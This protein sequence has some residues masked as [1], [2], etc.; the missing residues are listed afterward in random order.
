MEKYSVEVI[1]KK[2]KNI[3]F[4]KAYPSSWEILLLSAT[5]KMSETN[6]LM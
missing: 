4:L 2:Q 6:E 3:K 5:A 1:K